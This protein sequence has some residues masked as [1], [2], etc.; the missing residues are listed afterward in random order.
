MIKFVSYSM[1]IV[2]FFYVC[3]KSQKVIKYRE[4]RN[5]MRKYIISVSPM[6]AKKITRP[7]TSL[8]DYCTVSTLIEF[9]IISITKIAIG[10]QFN[11]FFLEIKYF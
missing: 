8:R 5:K 6:L 7:P 10:S 1:L 9:R 2:D 4:R 3:V 11:F